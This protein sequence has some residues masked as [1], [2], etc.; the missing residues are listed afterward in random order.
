[1]KSFEQLHSALNLMIER[2]NTMSIPA[3][4]E[5]A[6]LVLATGI[7]EHKEM[8]ELLCLVTNDLKMRAD[9]EGAINISNFI[10]EKLKKFDCEKLKGIERA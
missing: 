1:M 5:D 4:E 7:K 2:K 3:N 9:K 6:D 8:K 10:W